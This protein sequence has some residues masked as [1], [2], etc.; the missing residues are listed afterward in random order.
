MS[1]LRAYIT[2]LH[3]FPLAAL[4]PVALYMLA[5]PVSASMDPDPVVFTH[6]KTPIRFQWNFSL[7]K[8]RRVKSTVKHI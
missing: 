5:V 8:V 6:S 3:E 2:F 4:P 7:H 1:C